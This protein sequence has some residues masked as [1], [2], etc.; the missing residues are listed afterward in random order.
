LL[1]FLFVFAGLGC[2][3]LHK[4]RRF[5]SA[6]PNERSTS[7][8]RVYRQ[9]QLFYGLRFSYFNCNFLFTVDGAAYNGHADCPSPLAPGRAATVYYDPSDPSLNSLMEFRTANRNS[10]RDALLD[11]DF[12]SV[13][14]LGCIFVVALAINKRTAKGGILVDTRGTLIYPEQIDARVLPG[15]GEA[16]TIYPSSPTREIASNADSNTPPT[17]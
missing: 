17:E 13:F 14:L 10:I 3:S 2:L 5:S 8:Q 9:Y 16:P 11:F 15:G 7:T 1:F 6:A 4:A 12:A